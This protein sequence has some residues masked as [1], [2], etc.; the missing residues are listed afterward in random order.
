[1]FN[2]FDLTSQFLQKNFPDLHLSAQRSITSTNAIAKE[3]AMK[4]SVGS[5]IYIS[6]TQTEGRGRNQNT[7]N[8]GPAGGALLMTLSIEVAK[9]PQHLTSPLIGLSLFKTVSQCWPTL[10]WSLKAPNDL[11]LKDKKVAGLLLETISQSSQYRLLI[12]FGM[13]VFSHPQNINT[14]THLCNTDGLADQV[15]ESDWT[16]FITTLYK[17]LSTTATHSHRTQLEEQ[18]M[19]DLLLSLN[20]NPLKPETF[21]EVTPSGDLITETQTISW[22]DL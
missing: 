6:E 21:V 10:E 4:E 15:T 11:Y 9:P 5:A 13:N 20:A 22:K 14:A 7:W 19:T 8:E 18:E 2:V 17:N 12:G 1:M 3:K 16:Q